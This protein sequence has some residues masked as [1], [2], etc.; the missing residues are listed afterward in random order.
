MLAAIT[1]LSSHQYGLFARTQAH[2][3]DITDCMLKR[4]VLAGRITHEAE[5]VYGMPGWPESW[6]RRLWRA[7]LATGPHAVV[8]FETGAALHHLTN[9]P[10][11]RLVLTTPHGDHHWHGL[12]EMR[13][14]TDLLPEHITVIAGLRVTSVVRTLF[15]LAAVSGRERLAVAIEDSHIVGQCRLEQLQAFYDELRR[16]GKRGMKK[17]GKI[18]ADRGPGY[19]PS[20]SWLSRRLVAILLDGGLPKPRIEP[21]LPWRPHELDRADAIY[22]VERVLLEADGRRWH[23]RV[24]QMANDRRRDRE[25][26]NHGCRPYR[27]VYQE[28]RYD[29]QMVVDTVREA[30]AA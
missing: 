25:A 18:L 10:R 17:L 23:T 16:P 12:A 5:G 6:Y 3:S 27:F 20:Q 2:K 19:V 28:L 14:R 24:D 4:A 29:P 22:D 21:E 7:Y 13:Q 26:Q 9:F 8:S 15:D 11:G 30:L 1:E